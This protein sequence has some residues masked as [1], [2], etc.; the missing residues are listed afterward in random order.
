MQ[1]ST[2]LQT[3]QVTLFTIKNNNQGE[4]QSDLIKTGNNHIDNLMTQ[5]IENLLPTKK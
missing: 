3:F 4:R 2:K 1:N 5:E